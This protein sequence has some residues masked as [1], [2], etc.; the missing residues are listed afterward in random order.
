MTKKEFDNYRWGSLTKI[1]AFGVW[2]NID[3]IDFGWRK[4]KTVSGKDIIY[5][6]IQEVKNE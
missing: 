4:V 6:N 2:H 5:E 1:K 3:E